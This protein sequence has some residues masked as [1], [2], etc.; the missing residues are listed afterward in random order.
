MSSPITW[1]DSTRKLHELLPNPRNP[2][3]LTE[4]QGQGLQVSLKKFGFAI[5]VLISPS[6][7][8]LDGHQRTKLLSVMEE[9]G[10]EAEIPVRVSSREFT[11]EET[12]EFIVRLSKNQAG[13]DFDMLATD[14]EETDLINF[15]FEEWELS[16]GGEGE[17]EG[18][19]EGGAS[20]DYS[21]KVD[22]PVYEPTG[23]K[24]ALS[25]LCSDEKTNELI[26]EIQNAELPDDEKE[27]LMKCATR[28]RVFNYE[29]IAEYYSHSSKEVQEL[30]EKSAL[31]II[32]FE[33]AIEQ[34]YVKMSDA[35][36]DQFK[37]DYPEEVPQ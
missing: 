29:K 5:P 17:G 6:N 24:P 28:H 7:K 21:K 10:A 8:I 9:Y 12:K 16:I 15:G 14:Y 19:G 34:G 35:I 13:F 23:N 2:K 37:E 30:M 1:T 22:S 36:I 3:I 4:K 33:Q 20:D 25:E 32:D 26:E 27:F 31:V 18:E 11:D